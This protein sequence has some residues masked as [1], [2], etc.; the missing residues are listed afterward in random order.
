MREDLC[1]TV[2]K[3]TLTTVLYYDREIC[4]NIYEM[5]GNTL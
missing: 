3:I 2:I 5:I 4:P 1:N